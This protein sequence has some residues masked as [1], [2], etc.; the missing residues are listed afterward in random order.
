M[1]HCPRAPPPCPP[2][3]PDPPPPPQVVLKV[4]EI[5]GSAA[6]PSQPQQQQQEEEGAGPISL[7]TGD[8]AP[9]VRPIPSQAPAC[10]PGCLPTVGCVC[11]HVLCAGPGSTPASAAAVSCCGAAK[12]LADCWS[13]GSPSA[14]CAGLALPAVVSTRQALSHRPAPNPHACPPLLAS[15][16]VASP[17]TPCVSPAGA[18]LTERIPG[19]IQPRPSRRAARQ[20]HP[21]PCRSA[22]A[23]RHRRQQQRRRAPAGVQRGSPPAPRG[24]QQQRGSGIRAAPHQ[25]PGGAD[26]V[27]PQVGGVAA[28]RACHGR[29]A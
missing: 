18:G 19:S 21:Y 23:A 15:S 24:A 5:L 3:C 26:G 27:A 8:A 28:E 16:R 6:K 10:A 12:R 11:G 9:Q 1:R 2:A 29:A 7:G 14:S 22:A 17:T 13:R 4:K 20:R 25:P